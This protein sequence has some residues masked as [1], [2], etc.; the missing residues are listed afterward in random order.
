MVDLQINPF[1]GEEHHA[2]TLQGGKPAALLVHGFPGSPDEMRPLA[3]T[4]HDAGWT[5]HAL[6]LPGFGEDFDNVMQYNNDDWVNAVQ[7]ALTALQQSN[8][9]VMLVAHSL[10]G[11]LAIQVSAKTAPDALI[12]TAPFWKVDH[13]A[14]KALPIIRYVFP[15]PKLFKYLRLDFNKPDIRDG[16][17]NFMPDADLDDPQV[18]EAIINYRVPVKLFAQIYRAG[19][20]AYRDAPQVNVPALI[21]Q[22]TQ[23]ELV[24]PHL[25]Q[26]MIAQFTGERAYHEVNAEHDLISPNLPSWSR[27]QQLIRDFSRQITPEAMR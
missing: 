8:A 11:A 13:I 24:K 7:T 18:Q 17:H 15:Q 22:G 6:L 14:W 4:L 1:Q 25:T 19:Q 2:F 5:T 21:L 3:T 16:I 10:G 12:L 26:Q 27:M 23:D 9:P 20:K